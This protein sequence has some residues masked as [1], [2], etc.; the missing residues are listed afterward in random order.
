MIGVPLDGVLWY[1]EWIWWHAPTSDSGYM[2]VVVCMYNDM[3]WVY[4]E[5]EVSTQ[6]H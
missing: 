6:A 3:A 1:P 4:M 5:V 2:V